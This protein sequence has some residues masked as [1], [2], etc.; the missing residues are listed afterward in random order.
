MLS[1]YSGSF[2]CRQTD[3]EGGERETAGG[4]NM[5]LINYM[6][7]L[8]FYQA[9]LY[10]CV[11]KVSVVTVV[12]AIEMECRQEVVGQSFEPQFLTVAEL[13]AEERIVYITL[14][15]SSQTRIII[16]QLS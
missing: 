12:A 5:R 9:H 7:F 14:Y 6:C 13:I 8:T 3:V 16:H 15:I 1:G 11:Y 10:A 2:Q 4:G